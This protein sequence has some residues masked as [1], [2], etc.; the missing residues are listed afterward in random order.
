MTQFYEGHSAF[1]RGMGFLD[2]PYLDTDI[3][4][5]R[6]WIDGYVAALIEARN[7]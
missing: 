6:I 4:S 5:A 7:G 3:T 2:N 1:R